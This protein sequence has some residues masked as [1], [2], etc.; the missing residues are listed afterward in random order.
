MDEKCRKERK[1]CLCFFFDFFFLTPLKK[2]HIL[3]S[4]F[5]LAPN[6]EYL[7]GTL[8]YMYL[9]DTSKNGFH[10]DDCERFNIRI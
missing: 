9:A 6:P 8:Y 2:N 1:K 3:V 4:V 5:L 10:F 7:W